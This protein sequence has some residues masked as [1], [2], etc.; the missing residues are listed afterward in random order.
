LKSKKV[1]K[2]NTL[3]HESQLDINSFEQIT[4]KIVE[5]CT[6]EAIGVFIKL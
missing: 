5:S 3:L 1:E 6:K 2:F 4:N